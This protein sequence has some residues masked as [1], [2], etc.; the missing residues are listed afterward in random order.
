MIQLSRPF[1]SDKV[2]AASPAEAIE[3]VVE[4]AGAVE[5]SSVADLGYSLSDLAIRSL[6]IIHATTGLPWWATI[7]ATTITVR[8][9]LFPVT[10]KS[11]SAADCELL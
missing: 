11:V 10:V 7:V 6:D 2:V 8:T 1:D 9:V 3:S 4:N 5:F